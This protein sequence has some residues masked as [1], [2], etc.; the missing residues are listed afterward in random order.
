MVAPVPALHWDFSFIG[1]MW[2]ERDRLRPLWAAAAVGQWETVD[3][4]TGGV[5]SAAEVLLGG[6]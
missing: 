1:I 5:L 6:V 2:E 4:M 3:E